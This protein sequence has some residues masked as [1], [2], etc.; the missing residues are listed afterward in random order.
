TVSDDDGLYSGKPVN[1]SIYKNLK[2]IYGKNNQQ[3]P[4]R[5]SISFLHRNVGK[6]RILSHTRNFRSVHDRSARH[7]RNEFFTKRCL[8]Y[9][10]N[11]YRSH[12][13]DTIPW[14]LSC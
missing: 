11:F 7:R 5:A 12:L 2:L 3:T 9:L 4:E 8:R 6:V 10:W 1:Y 14:R 13:S